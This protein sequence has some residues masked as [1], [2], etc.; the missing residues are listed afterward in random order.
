MDERL[1]AAIEAGD[2]GA[3]GQLIRA[4]PGL[5][6]DLDGGLSAVMLAVYHGQPEIALEL[7]RTRGPA[8]LFEA[9]ALGLDVRV[10]AL[11]GWD[12]RSVVARSPDGFTALHLAA[13]FGHP[14]V[15][16][17]LVD[18]GADI[19]SVADNPSKVQPLHSAVA[20]RSLEVVDVLFGAGAGVD[21]RQTGGFTPL[22]GAAAGGSTELVT[23]LLEAGA[24]GSARTDDGKTALDLAREHGHAEV[25][26]LLAG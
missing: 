19:E 15:V 7:L 22:M 23:R 5:A 13:F 17:L 12:P 26:D 16:R 24:D 2:G 11:I 10:R 9:A 25:E 21:A 4:D 1:R 14:D 18:A 6:A 3:V 20:G 8:D